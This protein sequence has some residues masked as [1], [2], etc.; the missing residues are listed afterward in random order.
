M[1]AAQKNVYTVWSANR[2]RKTLIV[3]DL[4]E[5]DPYASLILKGNFTV[6]VFICSY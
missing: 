6:C 1:A 4:S 5:P 2:L 3:L